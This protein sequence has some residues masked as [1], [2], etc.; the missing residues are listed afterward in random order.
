MSQI[1]MVT[2]GTAGDIL[3]FVRLAQGLRERGHEPV[4]ITHQPYEE[5]AHRVGAEFVPSDTVAAFDNHMVKTADLLESRT[6]PE[7]RR[8]YE[9]SGA[10]DQIWTECDIL[11]ARHRPGDTILVGR[12]GT[13]LSVLIA[14]ELLG[15][16]AAWLVLYPS[17]LMT[18]PVQEYILKKAL[19]A[20]L[21]RGRATYGLGPVTDFPAWLRS[22]RVMLGLWP[23]WLDAAGPPAPPHVRVTGHVGG[24]ELGVDDFWG[25]VPEQIAALTSGPVPPVLITGG[26][27]RA[28]HEEFY[29]VAVGA[30]AELDWP[31]LVVS[32]YRDLLPRTLPSTMTW[33]PRA[34]FAQVL[35]LFAAILHHGGIGTV[36]RALR[37]GVPQV[38]MPHGF[39]RPDNSVRLAGLGLAQ[40]TPQGEWTVPAVCAQLRQAVADTG[41]RAR[42]MAVMA[43]DDAGKSVTAAAEALEAMLASSVGEVVG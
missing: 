5:Y 23:E 42:A 24:D 2:H 33:M 12:Y 27:G 15:A 10:F 26:T 22:P 21:N 11:A 18:S 9:Q 43:G 28:L 39:D 35:P 31:T 34:P 13:A 38:I 29:R 37:A 19:E 6:A 1:F 3:P 32:P 14:A 30:A 41:Y 25:Q 17:Q 4:L 8:F 40:F 7:V 20:E 36:M 16:P